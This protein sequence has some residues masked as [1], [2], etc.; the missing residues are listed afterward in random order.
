MIS[1]ADIRVLATR[2]FLLNCISNFRF[3]KRDPCGS[4]K[5]VRYKHAIKVIWKNLFVGRR[6]YVS[7]DEGLNF[8]T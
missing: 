2:L 4:S 7:P 3:G 8:G 5:R 6:V 1:M